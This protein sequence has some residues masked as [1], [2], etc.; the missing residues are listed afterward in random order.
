MERLFSMKQLVCMGAACCARD[1]ALSYL[2]WLFGVLLLLPVS[3]LVFFSLI[4]LPPGFC[5]HAF[6]WGSLGL[7]VYMQAIFHLEVG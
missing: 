7:L 3:A 5:V 4:L 2:C 1:S 6:L